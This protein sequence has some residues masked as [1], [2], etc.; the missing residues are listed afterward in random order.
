[1]NG[2]HVNNP[3]EA[4]LDL[5]VAIVAQ[6]SQRTIGRTLESLAGLARK[7]VVVDGGSKDCTV[8]I[9]RKAGA[10]VIHQ[11]WQGHVK[12][13]QFAVDQCR[14]CAWTLLLDS[15]E[16]LEPALRDSIREAVTADN[17]Q[18]GGWMVNRKIWFLGGWLNYTYQ[19]EWRLRL[20]RSTAGRIAG[21][22]P[23]DRVDVDGRVGRLKGDLRHDTWANMT[24]MVMRHLRYA[25]IACEH[26][27]RG[28]T[29]LELIFSPPAALAKQLLIK[30]GVLDGW[31]GV[32]VAGMMAHSTLLKHAFLAARRNTKSMESI[33]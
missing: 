25:Q 17:R 23:H 10:E 24:D 2:S 32:L 18:V 8:E 19:P 11:P 1:M 33:R 31:R 22:D 27:A 3:S 12:Q 30:R 21:V 20:F 5:G 7:I 16:A 9:S 15:D 4:P 14:D 26:N 29:A 13:K 28:G 6:D